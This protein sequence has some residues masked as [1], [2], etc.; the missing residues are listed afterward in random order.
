MYLYNISISLVSIHHRNVILSHTV[1]QQFSCVILLIFKVTKA[2]FLKLRFKLIPFFSV[3]PGE[4]STPN[5]VTQAPAMT[6][7]SAPP[8]NYAT[9]S[10]F[11]FSNTLLKLHRWFFVFVNCQGHSF[12]SNSRSDLFYRLFRTN[13]YISLQIGFH[14]HIT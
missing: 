9:K 6:T 14:K 8:G 3:T 10:L 11:Y 5:T 13:M 1:E 2:T 4:A 12:R 7:T